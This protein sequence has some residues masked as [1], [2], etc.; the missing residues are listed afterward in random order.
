MSSQEP[1][2]YPSS[3]A[4][5]EFMCRG[6]VRHP[7]QSAYLPL[8]AGATPTDY[9]PTYDRDKNG[10]IERYRD[11]TPKTTPRQRRPDLCPVCGTEMGVAE[12]AV[13]SGFFPSK[14]ER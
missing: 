12:R 9:G 11:G 10:R 1:N 4:P 13:L 8:P 7:H 3:G 14:K 2:P 6:S 5:A